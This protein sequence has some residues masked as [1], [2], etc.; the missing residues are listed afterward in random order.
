[1]NFGGA[2][3]EAF[4]NRIKDS[5]IK[6]HMRADFMSL[7][8]KTQITIARKR[9]WFLL[10]ILDQNGLNLILNEEDCGFLSIFEGQTVCDFKYNDT[11]Q[12]YIERCQKRKE[13]SKK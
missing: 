10:R 5:F 2:F 12:A 6:I 1:M 4:I 11:E 9:L 7:S 8:R 3:N 13:R